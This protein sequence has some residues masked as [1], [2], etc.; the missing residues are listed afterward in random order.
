MLHQYNHISCFVLCSFANNSSQSVCPLGSCWTSACFQRKSK[1]TPRCPSQV[2]KAD[3]FLCVGKIISQRIVLFVDQWLTITNQIK[4]GDTWS[5]GICHEN[6]S[7]VQK[8][9][10]CYRTDWQSGL[11]ISISFTGSRKL[12]TFESCPR[13]SVLDWCVWEPQV[14]STAVGLWHVRLGCGER[15]T[16]RRTCSCRTMQSMLFTANVGGLGQACF[17]RLLA[18][19]HKSRNSLACG[20]GLSEQSGRT[21]WNLQ[22]LKALRSSEAARRLCKLC[23]WPWKWGGTEMFLIEHFWIKNQ[24]WTDLHFWLNPCWGLI[25][26]V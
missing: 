5:H 13:A 20:H 26:L 21:A 6:L 2:V 8:Q 18:V 7:T 19:E 9:S 17:C 14:V 3:R 24:T 22:L 10:F 23:C 11:C 15:R 1:M 12:P 25:F 4:L 16:E